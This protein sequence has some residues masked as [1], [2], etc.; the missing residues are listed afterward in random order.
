MSALYCLYFFEDIKA[1]GGGAAALSGI[2]FGACEVHLYLEKRELLPTAL[3]LGN[4]KELLT[5]L[6]MW[7]ILTNAHY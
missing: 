5:N 4:E 6:A 2:E 3:H 7:I 1:S